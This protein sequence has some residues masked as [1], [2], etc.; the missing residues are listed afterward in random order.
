VSALLKFQEMVGCSK[1]RTRTEVE[2]ADGAG[3]GAHHEAA[4]VELERADD[5]ALVLKRYALGFLLPQV[6]QVNSTIGS[7]CSARRVASCAYGEY[8]ALSC[9]QAQ[10][11]RTRD[12]RHTTRC[13][14]PNE[15]EHAPDTILVSSICRHKTVLWCTVMLRT[16]FPCVRSHTATRVGVSVSS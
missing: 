3:L 15:H 7:S 6:A 2:D 12:T 14:C 4:V 16:I 8:C 5:S 13:I 9:S 10:P 11:M 1:L